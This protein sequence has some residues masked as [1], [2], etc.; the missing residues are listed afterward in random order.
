MCRG[1][2]PLWGAGVTFDQWKIG[3]RKEQTNKCLL[4]LPSR[5]LFHGQS[6]YKFFIYKICPETL[7]AA[8]KAHLPGNLVY[9]FTDRREA[10]VSNKS[11]HVGLRSFPSSLSFVFSLIA[12]GLHLPNK[13]LA[14]N[15]CLRLCLQG[16]LAK[17]S[18][19]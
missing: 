19:F 6:R 8:A 2:S 13:A 1:A 7:H 9:L 5:G 4:P 16:T 10:A 12:R 14:L 3:H 11:L 18:T 15:P 17:I